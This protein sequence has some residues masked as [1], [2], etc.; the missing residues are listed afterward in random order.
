MKRYS[1]N[2]MSVLDADTAGLSATA[3]SAELALRQNLKVKAVQMPLGKDP[4]DLI[5]ENPKEFSSSITAAK[6]VVDFF[7]MSLTEQE[8]DPHRLV[9]AAEKIVL[10]LIA[11]IPSPMEREHFMQIA[12]RLLGLSNESI[13]ESLKRLQKYPKIANRT[14]NAQR[15]PN[16]EKRSARDISFRTAP[17]RFPRLSRNAACG[18]CQIGVQS[19]YRRPTVS[20]RYSLGASAF[21]GGTNVR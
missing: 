9:A 12:A 16:A 14:A 11:A 15:I 7:L 8:R 10:P 6:P 18:T 4:A 17:F 20:Y 1:E 19:N 5:T 13:R 3:R 21:S 2:L